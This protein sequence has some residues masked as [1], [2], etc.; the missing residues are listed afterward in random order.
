M[1]TAGLPD[2]PRSDRQTRRVQWGDTVRVDFLAWLEDGTLIDSSIYSEPLIFTTG[3]RSVMQGVEQ[4]VIG[5]SVGESKTE[6]ISP[7][8]AFGPYRPELSCQVSRSWLQAQDV[9]PVVGLGLEVRKT[10]G[11]LVRMI[12][13]GLDGDRVTLDA[14]HRFAGKHFMVQLDLLEILDQAGPGVRATPTTAA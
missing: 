5:M 7:D 6:K 12:I 9:V 3:T 13:T 11:T 1:N 4:L 8:S 14:N 2:G 10:D